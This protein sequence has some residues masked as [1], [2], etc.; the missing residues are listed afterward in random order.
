MKKLIALTVLALTFLGNTALAEDLT[1]LARPTIRGGAADSQI[2]FVM[3]DRFFNAD[4]SNDEAGL[5]GFP[6]V[7]GYDPAD[8]GYFHGGDLQG[9]TSK[10]DYIQGLGFNSI[11]ITPP[12]KQRYVQGDSAAY[13]GYWGLDFTTIDPHLGTEADFKNFVAEAHKRNMKVIVD[14]VINHTGDVI[15]YKGDVYSYSEMSEYPYKDCSGKKFDLNK[16]IGKSNFPKLCAEKSFPVP[17]TVSEKNKNI[18]APAFL[19]DITNYHNRGDSTFS[20]ESSTFGDF[21]GLDDTF[22]EKPAVIAGW[23]K[24]WQDWITKFDIDGYRIDTAKHVNSEFWKV[25]LPAV[26]K[27]AKSVGKSS[28][29]IYGEVWDTD[30]NYLAKYVT[31]Y[32]FPGVLDFAFQ[33]AASKYATYGNGERDLLDIFNQDDLYT[34]ATTSAY[35]LTTFLDNHDMG[36]IGM[37]LQGN[38]EATPAQLVERANFANA[39]LI[40]LRGGPATYYGDEKGMTGTGGDKAARQDMFPTQVLDWQQETRIGGAQIGTKSAFDETNPIE[41]NLSELQK[42]AAKY[43]ALRLGTQQLRYASDGSFAVSRYLNKEEFL[44]AFN[45]RDVE[46]KLNLNVSTSNSKWSQISGKAN[47]VSVNGKLVS[48]NL[49]PRSWVVLKAESEFV[50]T[51]K[52]SINLNKPIVDIRTYEQYVALTA[53]VPGTDF[54]EVTFAVRQKGKP[55]SIVGTSDRRILG[56]T[57]FKDGQYRVYLHQ[58]KY[59]KGTQLEIVAIAVNANGE[60]IA[61]NLQNF[62]IK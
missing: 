9:L 4:P 53:T 13:H 52:L 36:R 56:V 30:P 44:V 23:T 39:L 50:P 8:I 45:G 58:D 35:G 59:K 34:T 1:S 6:A 42:L 2:Y 43:P 25:F 19:N 29:P 62:L 40:L 26:I 31:E 46:A 28:F 11:W 22:T 3:T 24:V 57:G 5:T 51:S 18:K 55:W 47:E 20:G 12:V 32:K 27:T 17:P 48:L 61:S 49:L 16:Y 15:R 14:I 41:I 33:A 10:L 38:T 60:K 54:N 37:F 7:T 21:F